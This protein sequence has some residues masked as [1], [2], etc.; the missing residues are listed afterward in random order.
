MKAPFPAPVNNWHNDTYASIDPK[1]PE[2]SAKGR[3]IVITGGG[4]GIGRA[5]AEAFAVAGASSIA[6]L[7]RKEAPL[8]ETKKHIESTYKVSVT[9]HIA[10][11]TDEAAVKKAAKEIGEWHVLDMNA[12][13]FSEPAGTLESSAD[14]WFKS[15]EV[16][17][18]P[19]L[20]P[21]CQS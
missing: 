12:G 10:D 18:P 13:Y 6:I 15:F 19:L 1:R 8:L 3:K 4:Y 5:T 21:E 11:I 14:E 16:H 17:T 2:L 7:G 20:I 9:T